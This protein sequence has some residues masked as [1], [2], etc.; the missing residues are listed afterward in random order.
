MTNDF[1]LSE[2]KNKIKQKHRE[3]KK[4]K[5]EK[6]KKGGKEGGQQRMFVFM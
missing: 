4:L 5:R 3:G 2:K 6:E 1:D